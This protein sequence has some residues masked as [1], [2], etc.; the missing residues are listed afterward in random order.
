MMC[1]PHMKTVLAPRLVSTEPA[2]P[3]AGKSSLSVTSTSTARPSPASSTSMFERASGVGAVTGL[4]MP[5][6]RMPE[7]KLPHIKLP[8][9]GDL[10]E[11]HVERPFILGRDGF[12]AVDGNGRIV[13]GQ[14][15]VARVRDH[16]FLKT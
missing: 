8:D 15:P 10:W 12:V 7:L 3:L 4:A 11:K 1:A 6:L 16:D 2:R 13:G 14:P 9:I 5:S